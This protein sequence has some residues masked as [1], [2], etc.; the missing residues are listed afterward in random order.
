MPLECSF[1]QRH[2]RQ[3]CVTDCPANAPC[4][5]FEYV[6]VE[7][8]EDVPAA[9]PR[10]IDVAVLDL[11][12]GW[13][14]LGHDSL[15]HA[16]VDASCEAIEALEDAGLRVRALS[17]DVRRSGMLPEG[18]GPRYSVYVG[19][20][21]PGHIDPRRNDGMA[22]FAQGV[23]E[24]PAWEAPAFRLFDAIRASADAALLAVCHSFGVLCR[25]S[26]AAE[27]VLRGPEKGKC[28]GV[29]ENV[30]A[31][32]AAEHP[33][34]RR[35]AEL[36]GPSARFRVVE[37]RLFDLIPRPDRPPWAVPLGFETL[38]VG[39][40]PGDAVTMMEF[41]RDR[42]GVVPRMLAVNHHPEIVDRFRQVMI[43][44]R[45]RAR[46]EVTE[47]WYRERLEILTRTYPAEDVDQRL[48][49]TSDFTLLGP[50]RFHLYRQI[51]LRAEA[52][53][54]ASGLHEDGVLPAALGEGAVRGPAA[55]V[56]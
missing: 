44:D 3:F 55:E 31:T 43:L 27:P 26:R 14:N 1:K 50:L 23:R 38:G 42:A 54:R 36:L 22:P 37:N 24:N 30:L 51:R 53:G 45:K 8:P 13:P 5:I 28:S 21:G 2:G 33:W 46:G 19:T 17:F 29:L 11:N 4:G 49:L 25:W 35:F 16:I 56:F 9:D 39:G 6:R 15:V 20:G 10:A 34:F 48:H 47:D 41:A 7:R 32:R 40:A 52:F 18:P 12:H